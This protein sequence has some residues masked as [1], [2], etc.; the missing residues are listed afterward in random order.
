MRRGYSRATYA[1]QVDFARAS[2]RHPL[3]VRTL[4]VDD[5]TPITSTITRVRL[6]GDELEGFA[7]EGPADHVKLC[8][9]DP[10]T[11][12]LHA[13]VLTE[14]GIDRSRSGVMISRDYTPLSFDG[15]GLEIDFVLHGAEGPA[16]AWALQAEVG[17][18]LAVLGPRGSRMAPL[19]DHLVLVVDETAFPAA[20]RWLAAVDTTAT[21]IA[22]ADESE[23]FGDADVEWVQ[24]DELLEAVRS[25]DIG[26]G[27]FLFAA[28][29]ASALVPV[30]RHLRHERMLPR[31]QVSASGYWRRGV[32]NLDHHAPLDPSDPD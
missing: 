19:M 15:E 1:R 14:Q 8:F 10:G 32:T 22:F 21:I 20:S 18:R 23:Y 9:P 13:P 3:A 16:S 24:P 4:D 28:G 2:L 25:L 6:V 27:T 7:A 26:D 11:G 31:E 17:Q 29:E 30:R 5:V 12:E